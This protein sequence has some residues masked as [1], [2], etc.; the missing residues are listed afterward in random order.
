MMWVIR[1]SMG[2]ANIG[3]RGH[4]YYIW[5]WVGR[6]NPSHLDPSQPISTH[7]NP[8]T[9]THLLYLWK[10][11]LESIRDCHGNPSHE[12]HRGKRCGLPSPLESTEICKQNRTAEG[13]SIPYRTAG[14]RYH[15]YRSAKGQYRPYHAAIR[16][17]SIIILSVSCGT[18]ITSRCFPIPSCF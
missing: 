17:A 15:R 13:P 9:H 14:C 11:L 1:L 10:D 7:F 2:W 3:V 6:R 18:I 12:K 5:I 16:Q 4:G 8:F